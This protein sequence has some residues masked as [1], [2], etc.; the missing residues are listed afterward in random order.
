[1]TVGVSRAESVLEIAAPTRRARFCAALLKIASRCNLDCD[2]CYMYKHVDQT[3]QTQPKFMSDETLAAFA[4]RLRDY[5]VAE[6]IDS[7]SVIF[8]GGE[9]LLFGAERIA[10]AAARI[11]QSVPA[12]CQ[13]EFSLQTN[14]VLVTPMSLNVLRQAGVSVSLSLDG[15]RGVHDRHR[16]SH[17]GESTYDSTY[18]ALEL[19]RREDASLFRGVIAVIDADVPPRELLEFFAPMDLPRLDFLLPDATHIRPPA[20]RDVDADRY[21]R[22]VC[23]AFELWFREFPSIPIRWFDA[24]LASRLGVPS[25]TDIMGFGSVSLLVADTD[26]TYSDHDVFKIATHGGGR[27]GISVQTSPISEAAC[28]PAI[29]EHGHRLTMDGIAA[30]C[31]RCP[32]VE[33]CGGGCVMH[34]AHGTRGLEAPTIYCG[35]MFAL[36]GLASRLLRESFLQQE[37]DVASD[38][39]GAASSGQKP[40]SSSFPFESAR[41]VQACARWRRDTEAAADGLAARL[42]VERRG[43]AAAILLPHAYNPDASVAAFAPSAVHERVLWLNTVCMQSMDQRLSGSFGDSIRVCEPESREV[44]HMLE[45]LE[46]I[47]QCLRSYDAKLPDAIAAL[48]SDIVCVE[49]VVPDEGGIFSFS[50]DKAPNV[51]YIASYAGGRPIPPED[52]ADSIYHEFL[53]QVLYHYERANGP[54]LFE[55]EYPRF[56]APWRPGLRPAIGFLHGT[57]V[58]TGLARLWK[59]LATSDE[60]S[61]RSK[62]TRNAARAFEQARYGVASLRAFAMLTRQGERLVDDLATYLG[63]PIAAIKPPGL[64]V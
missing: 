8:H 20:G 32:V 23:S 25:P 11:R 54:L 42:G 46:R 62:A 53:H 44:R 55:R 59:A 3:W 13:L 26:G 24:V 35:E 45:S 64:L 58:F 56:T 27:L 41:L 40:D 30:E 14:G 51:V 37:P 7:F 29:L 38:I 4:E 31:Q 21:T 61:D 15:P 16:L 34:R 52:L 28:H 10:D 48:I 49:S 63:A 33:A 22:W 2:Y 47:E 12:S 43:S 9:P 57:F 39:E 19:L 18:A 6:R 17:A 36:F 50:D 5:V 60:V 1:M